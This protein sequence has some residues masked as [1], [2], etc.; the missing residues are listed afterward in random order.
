[1]SSTLSFAESRF[2]QPLLGRRSGAWAFILFAVLAV[3]ATWTIYWL[4]PMISDDF[5][6]VA[7]LVTPV[8]EW[9]VGLYVD[10]F[11]LA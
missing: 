9:V 10:L 7:R 4:T 2:S 1:M 8:V 3:M 6:I 5:N 11:G